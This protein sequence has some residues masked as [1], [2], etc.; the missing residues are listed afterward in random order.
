MGASAEQA[1]RGE[2]S[3][4]TIKAARAS[5]RP[6]MVDF[7]AGTCVPCKK[8]KPIL[9]QAEKDYAGRAAIIFVDVHEEGDVARPYGIRLI[10][11][12]IFFDPAGREV[13]R[14]VGFMD[15]E[16]IDGNLKGL[17]PR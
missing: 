1:P 6:A 8:M 13:S 15:R 4:E 5:G 3:A 9:E 2:G 10:P 12:Q 16:G 17:L 7:G 14:H 11:T